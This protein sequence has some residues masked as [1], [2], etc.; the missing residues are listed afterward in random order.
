M[1]GRNFPAAEPHLSLARLLWSLRIKRNYTPLTLWRDFIYIGFQSR[2]QGR[3]AFGA[4][5][6]HS[7]KP[8]IAPHLLSHLFFKDHQSRESGCVVIS[9]AAATVDTDDRY[10]PSLRRLRTDMR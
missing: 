1:L 10:Q 6:T 3:G 2:V 9:V 8:V 5:H 7:E 4:L